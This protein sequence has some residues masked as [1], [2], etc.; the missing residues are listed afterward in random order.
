[1][2]VTTLP[3]GADV[4]LDGMYIGH[5]PKLV[6]GLTI[7]RHSLSVAKAGWQGR[8]LPVTIPESG[9]PV[10][11]SLAL[12]RSEATIAPRG[13][14]RLVLHTN[15][16]PPSSIIVDG[17]PVA[18]SKGACD[19]PA[20]SHVVVIQTRY[21]RVTRRVTIYGEMSTD[22]IVREEADGEGAK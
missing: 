14:G 21:G 20:G 12:E 7:G 11:A 9:G 10:I 22:M 8:D 6:D 2:Y 17:S 16:A 19:L 13:I 4:W 1:M 5:S 18:L 3:A 15:E